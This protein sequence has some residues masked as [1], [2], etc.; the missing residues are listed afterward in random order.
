[1]YVGVTLPPKRKQRGGRKRKFKQKSG[2]EN[3][4]DAN[5]KHPQAAAAFSAAG[6]VYM[7]AM[8]MAQL[9]AQLN[10]HDGGKWCRF[11]REGAS[12]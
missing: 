11:L 6:A 1:M 5:A 10:K 12:D 7:N 9:E 2:L 8:L 4:A 3:S